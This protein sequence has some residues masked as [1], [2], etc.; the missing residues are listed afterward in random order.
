VPGYY[1]GNDIERG[2]K[3]GFG[4]VKISGFEDA[5]RGATGRAAR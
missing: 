2:L 3:L 1:T 5:R 4:G